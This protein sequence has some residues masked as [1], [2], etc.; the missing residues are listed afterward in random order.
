M[1]ITEIRISRVDTPNSRLRGYASVTF[2]HVFVVR[3]IRIIEGKKGLFVAMPSRKVQDPCPKCRFRNPVTNRYCGSCGAHLPPF[4][5]QRMPPS[6][7]HRDLAHPISTEFREYL[8]RRILEAYEHPTETAGQE[9]E[10]PSD[11]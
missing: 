11:T 10:P 6:Q 2:D 8:Q 3:D 5:E 9:S 1:E 4:D 7:Q